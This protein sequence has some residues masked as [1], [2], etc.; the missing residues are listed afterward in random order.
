M[1]NDTVFCIRGIRGAVVLLSRKLNHILTQAPL[2]IRIHKAS[3]P[4]TSIVSKESE[5][6]GPWLF[7]TLEALAEAK[8]LKAEAQ[9]QRGRRVSGLH[10]QCIHSALSE[11][12][13]Q[14]TQ[15]Q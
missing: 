10:F 15:E 7:Q 4:V 14:L 1:T 9:L 5:T 2:Q 6:P 13:A 12:S 3:M 8:R 11:I